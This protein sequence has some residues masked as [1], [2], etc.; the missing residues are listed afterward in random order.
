MAKNWTEAQA[1][2]RAFWT[3]IYVDK[4][5]DIQSYMPIDSAIAIDF[6]TKTLRRH[7]VELR[8]LDGA[9][10]ADIGCGP[11]GILYGLQR[12]RHAFARPPALIGVDPL[13]DFYVS[14][15]GLLRPGGELQ[16]H[17]ARAEALPIGDAS[18]DYVFC[19]NALDHMEQ[20]ARSAGELHRIL[21]P[22][23]LC[24][25]SL[26]TIT[27]PFTPVRRWLKYIDSNHPHHFTVARVRAMLTEQ[28]DDVEVTYVAPMLEDQPEFALRH[29]VRSPNKPMAVMRWLSTFVLQSVYLNC[30]KRRAR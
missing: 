12:S 29:A 24:G 20:P 16:L 26:H 4:Q 14:S 1:K 22:G 3:R 15:V 19:V 21:K 28:F 5:V 30:R 2:E 27:R 18:C 17:E 9:V 10:V 23:G 6:M 13:M 25:V 7:R 8:A 11:Y